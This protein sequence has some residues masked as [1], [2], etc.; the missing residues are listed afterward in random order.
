LQ[1]L[2][3]QFQRFS[4]RRS[5]AP[6]CSACL[7]LL[8]TAF[9]LVHLA[10]GGGQTTIQA[11]VKQVLV[12]VVVT[13]K[14]GHHVTGMRASDFHIA[15]DGV[16]QDIVSLS[17]AT[18]PNELLTARDDRSLAAGKAASASDPASSSS[19]PKRTYL[20]CIDASLQLF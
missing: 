10:A 7:Y 2:A 9:S 3:V 8:L 6:A 16:S 15:E 20:T 12:P 17:T 13:D 11:D 19:S 14:A 18:S 1:L 4:R 5:H